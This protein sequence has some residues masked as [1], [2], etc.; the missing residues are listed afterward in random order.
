MRVQYDEGLAS[1]IDPKPCVVV[2][3]GTGEASVG[4]SIGQPLSRERVPSRCRHG[5]Q[6]GRQNI[7]PR[8]R[9]WCD[10]LAWSAH[11]GMSTMSSIFGQTNGASAMLTEMSRLYA[12]PT[13]SS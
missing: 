8:Q 4:E 11:P 3:E 9:K 1:H 7:V 10:D 5:C 2:R 13:T 12:T 6:R